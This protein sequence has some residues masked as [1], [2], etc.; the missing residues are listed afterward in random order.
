MLWQILTFYLKLYHFSDSFYFKPRNSRREELLDYQFVCECDACENNFPEV[1]TGEL[2]AVD[3]SLLAIAQKAYDNLRDPRKTLKPEDAKE[4]AIKY[5]KLMQKNYSDKN[6]PCR[7]I[8]LLQLCIIKCFL[9]ACK[10][11]ISFP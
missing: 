5:S 7:E 6:Y 2:E 4:L 1:M 11:T 8:V 9:V 3:K 10:S